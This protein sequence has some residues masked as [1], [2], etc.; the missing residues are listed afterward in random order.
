MDTAHPKKILFVIG[1]GHDRGL[2]I[3]GSVFQDLGFDVKTPALFASPEEVVA[4]AAKFR[5]DVIGVSSLAAA[6]MAYLPALRSA[7]AQAGLDGTLLA[8]GGIIPRRDHEALKREGVDVIFPPGQAPTRAAKTLLNEL[9][10]RAGINATL[11]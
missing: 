11:D 1:S 3:I 5:P 6:H 10:R 7:L 2:K 8:V 4:V 9:A